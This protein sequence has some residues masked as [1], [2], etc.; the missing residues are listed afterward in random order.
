MA[1]SSV[2]LASVNAIL[3]E[4]HR[5]QKVTPTLVP[6]AD[7]EIVSLIESTMIALVNKDKMAQILTLFMQLP[8][9]EQTEVFHHIE[10]QIRGEL[11]AG[12]LKAAVQREGG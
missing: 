11:T 7:L 4:I 2:R 10:E 9:D 5:E 6:L 3:D 8:P 1:D 12:Y